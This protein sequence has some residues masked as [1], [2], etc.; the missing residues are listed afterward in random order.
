MG[1]TPKKKVFNRNSKAFKTKKDYMM[2]GVKESEKTIAINAALSSYYSA[3][4]TIKD[5]IAAG[6]TI[7]DI[8]A[9]CSAE[10]D[11]KG[12]LEEGTR[13]LYLKG[14]KSNQ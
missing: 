5:L 7:A 9:F 13:N 3:I 10:L 8:E 12:M 2:N 14:K 1:G 4:Q 11:K 6:R